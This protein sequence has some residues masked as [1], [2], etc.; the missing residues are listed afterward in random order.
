MN[1]HELCISTRPIPE[2]YNMNENPGGTGEQEDIGWSAGGRKR[3]H[4]L[5]NQKN[6]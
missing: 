5:E 6:K 3:R 1:K 2:K 4:R